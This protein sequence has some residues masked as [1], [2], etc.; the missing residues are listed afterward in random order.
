MAVK[1]QFWVIVVTDPQTN[2]HTKRQD[3]LQYRYTAPL[4]LAR[5]V[6]IR[7]VWERSTMWMK[8]VIQGISGICSKADIKKFDPGFGCQE[9]VERAKFCCSPLSSAISLLEGRGFKIHLFALTSGI[10]INTVPYYT[11]GFPVVGNYV[12]FSANADNCLLIHW[13]SRKT[14]PLLLAVMW[15]H[16]VWTLSLR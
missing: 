16:I 2:T 7:W 12:T 8:T 3:R 11:V 10:T 6:T 13:I 1:T 15:S 9:I 5:I 14:T 4:S